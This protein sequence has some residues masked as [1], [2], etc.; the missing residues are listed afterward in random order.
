MV[1]RVYLFIEGAKDTANGDL[2]EGFRKLLEQKHCSK[3]P[4]ISMGEGKSQTIRKFINSKGSKLLCDLDTDEGQTEK[5]LI[6]YQIIDYRDD[7]FYMIQEME[8]WFISQPEVLD[9]F[10][11]ERISGKLAKKAANLFSEPDKELQR[12]TKNTKRG[13]YHKVRHGSMLLR[14]LN[15]HKLYDDFPDFKRLV[16][17]LQ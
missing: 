13:T 12:I 9:D 3:M 8:A 2:R 10:Y 14:K 7:V 11:S 15:A 4:T 1:K 16:D 17:S 5:D 6:S